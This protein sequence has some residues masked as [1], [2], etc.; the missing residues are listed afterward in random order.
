MAHP[1]KLAHLST[2]H[3]LRWPGPPHIPI[4]PVVSRGRRN[5]GL[6][7]AGYEFCHPI[8]DLEAQKGGENLVAQDKELT[9]FCLARRDVVTQGRNPKFDLGF[10]QLFPRSK[11][12]SPDGHL[13]RAVHGHSYTIPQHVGDI[14]AR[15]VAPVM[16]R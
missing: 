6:A 3:F 13:S 16:P 2:I 10:V 14:R 12:G 9:L 11:L 4:I 7:G 1:L 5:T 15:E 8:R